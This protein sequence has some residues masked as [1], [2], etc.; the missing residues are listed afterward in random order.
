[1]KKILSILCLIT[2]VGVSACK[3]KPEAITIDKAYSFATS[4]KQK[5]GAIFLTIQNN[6]KE[7]DKLISAEAESLADRVELHTH[8]MENGS[9]QMRQVEYIEVPA[10]SAHTL[11]PHGDHIMIMG[12]KQQLIK[13]SNVDLLLTFEKAGAIKTTAKIIAPGSKP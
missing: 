10:G 11:E 8:K 9:M 2:L 1:M 12:L 6:S 4:A 13:D 7:T 3:D 5:N